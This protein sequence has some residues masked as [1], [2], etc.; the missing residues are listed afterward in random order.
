MN[1]CR[2]KKFKDTLQMLVGGKISGKK[3][4]EG[5]TKY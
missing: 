1:S 4:T 3:I 2:K 5:M